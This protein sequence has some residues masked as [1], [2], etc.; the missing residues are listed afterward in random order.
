MPQHKLELKIGQPAICLRN[1]NPNEGLCNGTRLII[2][3][4][5]SRII[6]AEIAVG[7]HAGNTVYIPRMPLT[8]SDTDLPFEFKRIQ[9]PLRP[10]FAMTISKSQGQTL[11]FVGIWLH[12]YLFSHGQLYVAMSRVSAID[13]IKIAICNNTGKTRN[14]VYKEVLI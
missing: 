10:A 14:V 9:Y 7:V 5:H 1:V 6:E 4:F 8:P 11:D 13:N 2:K 3:R 12:D